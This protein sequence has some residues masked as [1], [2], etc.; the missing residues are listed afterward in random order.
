MDLGV[1]AAIFVMHGVALE[2]LR[3]RTQIGSG[4]RI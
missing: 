1:M 3:K 2:E 4:A